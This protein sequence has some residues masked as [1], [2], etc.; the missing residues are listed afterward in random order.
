MLY[1]VG[2]YPAQ[3]AFCIFKGKHIGIG[4]LAVMADLFEPV[5]V[6]ASAGVRVFEGVI[7]HGLAVARAFSAYFFKMD[8]IAAARYLKVV[9]VDLGR[10]LPRNWL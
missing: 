1:G 3:T 9:V 10:G 7:Q 8:A 2:I 5:I 6:Y 4:K